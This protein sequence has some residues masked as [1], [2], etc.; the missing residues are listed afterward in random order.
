MTG[1]RRVAEKRRSISSHRTPATNPSQRCQA[2][3]YV[4]PL[5]TLDDPRDPFLV[6]LPPTT[7]KLICTTEEGEI[8]L[9][10]WRARVGVGSGRGSAEE[11]A[12]V[13]AGGGGNEGGEGGDVAPEF[14]K[15]VSSDHTRPCVALDKSPFFP[16]V[17][18]SVGDWSF[19]IWKVWSFGHRKKS[20]LFLNVCGRC[21]SN[22]AFYMSVFCKHYRE[23][24]FPSVM[25][26][27]NRPPNLLFRVSGEDSRAT[28][29]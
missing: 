27:R 3:V 12:G 13:A 1:N 4:F 23:Q 19:Q 22:H 20:I 9:A 7:K 24:H 14:V 6:S 28:P 5:S 17:L 18:L 15:W 26:P 29:S 8:L 21:K 16:G 2:V 11:E 25:A 10:D